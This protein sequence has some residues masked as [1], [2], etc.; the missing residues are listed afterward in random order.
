MH[1]QFG[2]AMQCHAILKVVHMLRNQFLEHFYP[3][4]PSVI[5][6]TIY[7]CQ[8]S[9]VQRCMT[10]RAL[11]CAAPPVSSGGSQRDTNLHITVVSKLH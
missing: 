4:P 9:Y 7:T 8:L 1:Y 6:F 3:P 5:S 11:E 2:A 10:R